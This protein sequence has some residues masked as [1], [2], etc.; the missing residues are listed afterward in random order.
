MSFGAVCRRAAPRTARGGRVLRRE[1]LGG[2]RA[3]AG[4][5]VAVGSGHGAAAHDAASLRLPQN[6]RGV[7]LEVR[8]LRHSAHP[9]AA[10][11]GADGAGARRGAAAGRRRRARTDGHRAG[12]DLLRGRSLRPPPAGG[13]AHGA[14]PHRGHRVDPPA[15]RLSD[16]V[17]RRRDR[18][19]GARA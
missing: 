6:R 15:L 5:R 3:G 9:R 4:R 1:G 8:L 11:L 12:H 18:G 19:H 13:S 10:R 14:V 16:G 17:P 7:R 2:R